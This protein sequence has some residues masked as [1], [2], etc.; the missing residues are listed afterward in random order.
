MRDL[1]V[2]DGIALSPPARAATFL[3]A[4]HDCTAL[5]A[6]ASNLAFIAYAYL[7][8]LAPVLLLHGAVAAGQRLPAGTIV[9]WSSA[10][11]AKRKT[12]RACTC[13]CESA[14]F[15]DGLL[16]SYAGCR[17]LR[18]NAHT[19][20]ARNNGRAD[21]G[22]GAVRIVARRDNMSSMVNGEG[23][24]SALSPDRRR[25]YALGYPKRIPAL[26]SRASTP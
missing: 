14:A 7:E 3:H 4:F 16:R 25:S 23:S 21:Q 2:I 8:N 5:V 17:I 19:S 20:A 6:L 26:N 22:I 18:Y 13:N 10:T 12:R 11:R 1:S 9:Q 24:M 15:F